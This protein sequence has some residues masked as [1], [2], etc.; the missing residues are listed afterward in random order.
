M[1]YEE[2]VWFFGVDIDG[3][4]ACV[5]HSGHLPCFLFFVS[6][7]A[8]NIHLLKSDLLWNIF[9]WSIG[10]AVVSIVLVIAVSKMM[11]QLKRQ[12]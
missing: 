5:L 8:A 12:F 10:I 7:V 11:E 2:E 1:A 6:T 9:G 4:D 3:V